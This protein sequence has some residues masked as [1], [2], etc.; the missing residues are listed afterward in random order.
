MSYLQTETFWDTLADK[1]W[2]TY[3][4]ECVAQNVRATLSD[5]QIW[6][7]EHDLVPEAV[8]DE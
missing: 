3:K 8:Y 6:A 5:F 2:D 4:A 1:H 7:E